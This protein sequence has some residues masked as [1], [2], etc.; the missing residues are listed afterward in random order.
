M[1]NTKIEAQPSK[2]LAIARTL[3]PISYDRNDPDGF[4][5]WYSGIYTELCQDLGVPFLEKSKEILEQS[6][7]R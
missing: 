1:L 4:N 6:S 3:I 2:K 7:V 5:K